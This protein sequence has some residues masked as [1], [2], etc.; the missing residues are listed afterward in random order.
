[1]GWSDAYVQ[2][3]ERKLAERPSREDPFLNIFR[4]YIRMFKRNPILFIITTILV[5]ILYIYFFIK[6]V[7]I[8]K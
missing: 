2:E 4:I 8:M 1:M 7:P 5:I 3:L 6:L